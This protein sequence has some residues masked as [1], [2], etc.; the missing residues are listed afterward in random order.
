MVRLSYF[1]HSRMGPPLAKSQSRGRDL[2]S[3]LAGKCG[4]ELQNA[5]GSISR[6]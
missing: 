3:G 5:S 1:L 4:F 2:A 6:H